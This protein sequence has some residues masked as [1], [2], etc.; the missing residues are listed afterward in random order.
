M[1]SEKIS[2][3]FALLQCS[4][5]DVARH[6]G[7]SSSNIS[8]LRTGNR[9]P[10]A[11]SHTVEVFAAGVYGYADYE[12]LL[13]ALCELC[14][15]ADA[16][17]RT[18]IPALIAWLYD[19][20]AAETPPRVVVPKSKRIKALQRTIFGARLSRAMT[21]L[22]MTNSQL[23]ALLR[24][25]DSLIS[26]WRSG[27]HSPR[28]NERL[29]E[30]LADAM[31]SRAAETGKLPELSALC[32]TDALDASALSHWLYDASEDNKAALAKSLLQSLDS[33]MPGQSVPAAPEPP[34][35]EIAE[36]YWGTR[37][38]RAAA[39]RFLTDAANKGGELL[40][41]SDEPMEWMA[42]DRAY[43][44]LWASLMAKCLQRGVRVKIIHNLDRGSEEMVS[45]ISGWLPLY[46]SGMIE[47]YVFRSERNARF[48][49]TAFL[50]S[51]VACV[52][53]FFPAGAGEGRRYEYITDPAELDE[54]RRE[55]DA[56]LATAKPFLKTYTTAAGDAFR[57]LCMEKAGARA[58]LLSVP[59]AFT[60]PEKTLARMLARAK[61]PEDS[62]AETLEVYR[63][64]RG[65]FFKLL[66][67]EKV[68]L[69]LCSDEKEAIKHANFSLDLMDFSIEYTEKEYAEHLAAVRSL[70][71]NERNFHLTLLPRA[72]FRGIQLAAMKDMVAV[73]RRREPYAA[74]V[75][76]NPMLAESIANYLDTLIERYAADRADTARALEKPAKP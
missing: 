38:L 70:V 35:I 62:V 61:L 63:A 14:G 12:N 60:M 9:E 48:C 8:H 68:N 39:A 54:L 51:G 21:A 56:M 37:G 1:L 29:S 13:P 18:V 76:M 73:L 25:D 30:K 2:V 50:H 75:F 44:A 64:L 6:A 71:E 74:F 27:A 16:T 57:T 19:A 22:D 26:R 3:L 7:C 20:G 66:E 53:G 47:P 36:K 41:Y 65:R 59:P 31:L 55:Y 5:V 11:S 46:I 15:A 42:G 43:F 17:R 58:Y 69:L 34:E 52:Q 23:A 72:P 40:L 28:G 45:A 33:F 67:T 32:G 10:K 49:H 24:V 4:N